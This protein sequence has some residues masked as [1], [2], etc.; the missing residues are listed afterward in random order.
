M[1]TGVTDPDSAESEDPDRDLGWESQSRSGSSQAEMVPIKEAVI[2]LYPELSIPSLLYFSI[3]GYP[4]A[5]SNWLWIKQVW[6]RIQVIRIRSIGADHS[7]VVFLQT[8]TR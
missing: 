1:Q 6:I 2:S 8:A 4:D 7:L 3:S 5:E